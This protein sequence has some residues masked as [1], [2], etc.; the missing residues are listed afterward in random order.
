MRFDVV[1]LFPELVNSLTASGVVGRAAG[2]DLINLTCWNPRDYTQ[3][4]H[5]TVDDR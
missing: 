1:T 3:D 5:Q 2:Q 4:R